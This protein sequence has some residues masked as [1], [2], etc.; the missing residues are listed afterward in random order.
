MHVT[1]A[2]LPEATAQDVFNQVA[3]HLLTQK[4]RSTAMHANGDSFCVYRTD[5]GLMCAAGCLIANNEY[6]PMMDTC[7][8]VPDVSN[9]DT[10]WK[11]LIKQAMVPFNHGKMIRELQVIHDEVDVS[12]WKRRLILFA[13]D[14]ELTLPPI[15]Q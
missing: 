2:T 6:K 9:C 15:F 11:Q 1:L 12:G 3:T 4:K 14:W 5:N 10:N 13:I 7:L 8:M